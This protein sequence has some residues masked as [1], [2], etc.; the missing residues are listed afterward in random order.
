MDIQEAAKVL[1]RKLCG[2]V[3]H[4][5]GVGESCDTDGMLKLCVVIDTCGMHEIHMTIHR[6]LKEVGDVQFGGYA[7]TFGF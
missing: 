7:I 1:G 3:P 6:I 5:V 4:V 2:I